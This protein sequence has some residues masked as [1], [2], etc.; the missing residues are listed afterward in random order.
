MMGLAM[1]MMALAVGAVA[2]AAAQVPADSGQRHGAAGP[3]TAK[4]EAVDSVLQVQT[5][6]A[7]AAAAGPAPV[8]A[9]ARA[10]SSGHDSTFVVD[11]VVAV[12][13]NRAVLASQVQEEIFA[14]Q[15]Q[16]LQ[17]PTDP[18]GQ[19]ELRKQ[20]VQGIVE[21]E[22]LVQEAERDTSIKVTDQ[23][24]SE[25]VEQQ[26]K[27]IRSNFSSET[28]YATELRKSGFQTP[29]EYRRWL[30]DQQRRAA[31]Q[32]R[33]VEKLRSAQKLK[34]VIPTDKEMR[35]FFEAQKASFE[36]RPATLSFHQIVVTPQPS[37]EAKQRAYALAESIAVALRSGGDFAVAAKRFSADSASREQGGSLNWFRRG[38]MVPEF[39]RVA[40]ALKPGVISDPVES[41]FGYHVIQVERTQ[42][43]EIQA[44]HVLIM[45]DITPVEADSAKKLAQTLYEQLKRGA[46]FDS[47]QR[48]YHDKSEERD[49][50]DVPV[51]KLP[52]AYAQA[53][54]TA[55]AGVAVTPFALEGQSGRAKFAVVQVTARRNEGEVRYEDV[56]DK[57][58]D[59]L[60]Q[61]LAIRRLIDRLR[62][63]TYVE[64]RS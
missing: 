37:L 29:D 49:A 13:G 44:R 14:R 4:F 45:P 56:R 63:A 35:A 17:L 32:N 53:I 51:T 60:G 24:I 38:V 27:K 39:E 9:A 18:K 23:E 3:D 36:K 47:L 58:R 6:P 54:G 41:P 8:A 11:R 21:E 48:I 28:E 26:V 19:E 1:G 5:A 55:E 57:I 34:N 40:F 46:D 2:P 20:V 31:Y 62:N 25:G 43:G 15:G 7:T 33:Y 59:Q 52:P 10:D 16:G 50:K 22:L 30:A 12:V 64:V 42:P 61:Q